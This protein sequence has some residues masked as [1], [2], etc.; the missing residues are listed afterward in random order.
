MTTSLWFVL[1][2]TGVSFVAGYIC[3][4]HVDKFLGR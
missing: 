3:K 1:L 2:V 4:P